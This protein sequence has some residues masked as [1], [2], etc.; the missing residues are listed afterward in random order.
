MRDDAFH[1]TDLNGHRVHGIHQPSPS[2][3]PL[4][5]LISGWWPWA[6][7][8]HGGSAPGRYGRPTSSIGGRAGQLR[9]NLY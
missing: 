9:I 8:S 1:L 6:A 2:V 5:Q 4:S 3:E 7:P